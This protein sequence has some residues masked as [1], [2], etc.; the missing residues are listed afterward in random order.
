[1]RAA[2]ITATGPP[3]AIVAGELPAPAPGPADVLVAVE[4]VAVN[5]VDTYI[6][7]GRWRT[8]MPFPF[9]VGRDLVGTVAEGDRAG[10]FAPGDRVWAN[11]LGYAGRQGATAEYAVVPADRLYR[12]PDNADPVAAVA[13]LHPAATAFVGLHHRAHLRADQ[14]VLVGGGAGSVGGCAV[15]LAAA[16]GA[17]VIAT[18]RAEDHER[19]RRL[20]ADAVFDY[21]D[22]A[23]AEHVLSAAPGGV[24]VHWDTSGHGQLDSAAAM[25]RPGGRILVTAGRQPQ[26]PTPW[27]PLYTR[28]ISVIGFVISRATTAELADAARTINAHLTGPGFAVSVAGVLPLEE[29]RQ[30]HAEVESGRRGRLVIQVTAPGVSRAG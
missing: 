4:A 29:T 24:D 20:G 17:R 27:W 26:P 30:A 5:Q 2:F 9:V 16:A 28:D 6:R 3:D 21:R 12:L 23:L 18:A 8:A 15:R 25:V 7:G 13:S 11:S 10:I 22:Q 1:M 19:C 14:T